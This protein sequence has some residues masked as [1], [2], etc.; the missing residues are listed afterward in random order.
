MCDQLHS[1]TATLWKRSLGTH[2]K[3][4]WVG[5]EASLDVLEKRYILALAGI[6]LR[7]LGR[8]LHNCIPPSGFSTDKS[9]WVQYHWP[10]P[11][12]ALFLGNL[13]WCVHSLQ[14]YVPLE[15]T[16]LDSTFY[17]SNIRHREQRR[18]ILCLCDLV[19][20]TERLLS[21]KTQHMYINTVM[22]CQL[23]RGY[24]FRL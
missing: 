14:K 22:K 9:T 6:E 7:F 8:L 16:S 10:F 20:A 17:I 5:P 24:M 23:H 1:P 12:V 18:L 3:E 11:P 2:R 15:G 21:S 13:S 19:S 4:G